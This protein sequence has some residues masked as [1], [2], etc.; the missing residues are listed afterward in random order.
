MEHKDTILC[1]SKDLDTENIEKNMI[2]NN[3]L[4]NLIFL[5]LFFFDFQIV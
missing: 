5:L 2:K 3:I 4:K 1:V